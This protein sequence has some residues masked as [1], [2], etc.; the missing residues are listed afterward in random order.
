MRI[1]IRLKRGPRVKKT[2]EK[3]RKVA[4][5]VAALL[6]P[7]CVIT[8]MFT[9]WRIGADL[10]MTSG[11]AISSGLLSHWQVWIA[12]SVGVQFLVFSLNRY[13]RVRSG[14]KPR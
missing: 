2:V 14:R 5:A 9:A 8:W 6:T 11:F 12:I 4:L 7:V 3:D 1:S 10:D 13:G